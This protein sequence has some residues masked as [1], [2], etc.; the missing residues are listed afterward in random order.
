MT[1]EHGRLWWRWRGLVI[2]GVVCLAAGAGPDDGPPLEGPGRVPAPPVPAPPPGGGAFRTT[3]DDRAAAPSLTHEAALDP[4]RKAAEPQRAPKEPPPPVAEQPSA[5]PHEREAQWVGGYWA[6]DASRGDFAWV[7]G[8]WLL[9]PAG[10]IWVNGR[11]VRDADG[12]ARVPGVWSP[13]RGVAAENPAELAAD[14]RTSGPPADHPADTPGPAPDAEAFFVPGHYR[15][16]G[17]RLVWAPGFW[18]RSRPGWDW[19]PARWVRRPGG[20]D[21]REGYWT[22]DQGDPS[23]PKRPPAVVESEPAAADRDARPA[24]PADPLA[25]RED[26]ARPPSGAVPPVVIVPRPGV[27]RFPYAPPYV[28]PP[29]PG[30]YPPTGKLYDPYGYVGVYAPPFVTRMLD[31][32]LP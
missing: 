31:R 28:Y 5:G 6:W 23:D 14:W 24:D 25:G 22:R 3:G 1:G 16:E 27:Y 8:T 18:A 20:W 13:R 12:W 29:G 7:G 26:P 17:V 32:I 11:W 9:P 19:V 15:P 2:S 30:Y 10:R 21:Y 4:G